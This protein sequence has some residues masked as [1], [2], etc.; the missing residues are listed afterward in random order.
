MFKEVIDYL[1]TGNKTVSL[2]SI[3]ESVMSH[4]MAFAAEKSRVNNGEVVEITYKVK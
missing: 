4:E 1:L 2:T 3:Q